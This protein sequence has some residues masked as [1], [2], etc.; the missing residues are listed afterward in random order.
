[1]KKYL[2]MSVAV[3][4]LG[5]PSLVLA[6]GAPGSMTGSP[7]PMMGQGGPSGAAMAEDPGHFADMKSQVLQ[8]IE[9]HLSEVSKRKECVEAAQ[10]GKQLRTCFPE[11]NNGPN[12]GGGMQPMGGMPN[13]GS[14]PS[15][16]LNH[17]PQ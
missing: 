14:A 11:R 12:G 4:A 6:Q 8:R 17:A 16:M 3:V 7:P 13:G 10:D 15:N 5:M 1:M 2:L 9:M